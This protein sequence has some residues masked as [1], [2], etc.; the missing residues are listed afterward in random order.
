MENNKVGQAGN[1]CTQPRMSVRMK[2]PGF[3]WTDFHAI[4][5]FK[6]FRKSFEKIQVS[7]KSDTNNGYF[8]WGRIYIFDHI[9]LSYS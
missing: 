5:Y 6:L 3:H 4:C 1:V 7:L 8:I 9:S 2:E